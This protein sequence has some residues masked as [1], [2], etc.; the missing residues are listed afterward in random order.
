MPVLLQR[1]YLEERKEM[2]NQVIAERKEWNARLESLLDRYDA[3]IQAA[4]TAMEKM[5]AESHALRNK[6]TEFL[7]S[8]ETRL[9]G[10]GND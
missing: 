2:I 9:R 5:T 6:L 4:I 10:S 8:L 1:K 7:L 3:R